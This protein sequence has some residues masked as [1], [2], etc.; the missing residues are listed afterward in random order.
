MTGVPDPDAIGPSTGSRAAW[1]R[2]ARHAGFVAIFAFFNA[3]VSLR[4]P[5]PEPPFWWLI[6]SVDVIFGFAILSLWSLRGRCVPI[7]V[8]TMLVALLLLVRVVRIGDGV[9]EKYYGHSFNL[10]DLRLVPNIVSFARTSVPTWQFALCM[11]VAIAVLG[12]VVA[13]CFAALGHVERYFSDKR[14]FVFFCALSGVSLIA[15]A[16]VFAGSPWPSLHLGGLA[17]SAGPRLEREARFLLGLPKRTA[18]SRLA[19]AR[20]QEDLK[21]TPSNL[22]KLHG[23]NV[24]LI[25]V[26]SYGRAVFDRPYF[27][28]RVR[29]PL[30]AFESELTAEGFAIASGTLTSPTSGGHSWL[31]HTT[32]ATGIE[33]SDEARF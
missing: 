13:A 18:D 31:A 23:A 26:E 29:E 21:R 33:V 5:A 7:A 3:M 14:S 32:L 27:L 15:F 20:A 25:F 28:D 2:V 6:P 11:L 8:R 1:S 12:G 9:Q 30:R 16:P 17:A 22:A 24:L 4:Y 10:V 19:I